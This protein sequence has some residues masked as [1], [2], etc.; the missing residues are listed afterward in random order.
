MSPLACSASSP[1]GTTGLPLLLT[2]SHAPPAARCAVQEYEK[3][4]LAK[5][6]EFKLGQEAQVGLG[7]EARQCSACAIMKWAVEARFAGVAAQPQLAAQ[8]QLATCRSNT[9]SA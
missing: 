8:Q 9:A 4:L 1:S 2:P 5:D 3:R 6:Q 7:L